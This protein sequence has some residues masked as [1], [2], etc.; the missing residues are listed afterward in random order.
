M[1]DKEILTSEVGTFTFTVP[2]TSAGAPIY[3][4][5]GDFYKVKIYHG[6]DTPPANPT[7]VGRIKKHT[8]PLGMGQGYVRIFEGKSQGEILE[9]EQKVNKRWQGV[10]ADDIAAE[11]ASDLSLGSDLATDTTA[12]TLTTRTKTYLSLLQQLSDYWFDAGTQIKKDFYVNPSNALTWKSRPFRTSGVETL[13]VGQN[14]INYTLT[15]DIAS[16][17]NH[18]T[19]YGAANSYLPSDRD[20]WTENHSAGWAS[21]IGTLQHNAGGAFLGSYCVQSSTIGANPTQSRFYQA[22]GPI[23]IR[24]INTLKFWHYNA[25]APDVKA[26]VRLRAPDASNYFETQLNAGGSTGTLESFDLGPLNVYDASLNPSGKWTLTGSP[27]WWDI[28]A[29]EFYFS[30]NVEYPSFYKIDALHYLPVKCTST[31]EDS[32]SQTNFGRC[33]AE[34]T[35]ETL[36]SNNEC[37][38]RVNTLL[39]QQKDRVLRLDVTV[40]GNT[41]ILV[42]DRIPVTLPIDNISAI[43]FDV[44]AVEHNWSQQGFLTTANMIYS[45]EVRKL[46]PRTTVEAVHRALGD[47]KVVTSELYSHVIR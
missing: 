26:V 7:F 13:T 39:Y 28:E 10:E 3:D 19:V 36:L 29:V 25:A 9:R 22:H 1:R 18:I 30:A 2:A 33:D 11:I 46:P 41:N 32:T 20:Y 43:N 47:L 23:N 12:V 24:D 21:V 42:G 38:V 6:Y 27:N 35:D 5:I 17:K 8:S 15:Y 45:G 4:D 16:I 14:I 37:N 44:V 34:Y 31:V 40:P